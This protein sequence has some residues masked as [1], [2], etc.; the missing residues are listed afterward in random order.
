VVNLIFIPSVDRRS[1][2]TQ[3]RLSTTLRH[4]PS[5]EAAGDPGRSGRDENSVVYARGCRGFGFTANSSHP[6]LTPAAKGS[7]RL[8]ILYR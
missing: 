1:I 4:H 6:L 2:M 3:G 7:I 8:P 5:S